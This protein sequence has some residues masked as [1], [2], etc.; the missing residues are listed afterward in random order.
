MEDNS[1]E[2]MINRNK[3]DE[4]IMWKDSPQTEIQDI[5]SEEECETLFIVEEIEAI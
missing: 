1:M 2:Q 4:M 3:V 5:E